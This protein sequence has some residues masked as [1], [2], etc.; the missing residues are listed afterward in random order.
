MTH[1]V[2]RGVYGALFDDPDFQTLTSDAR[3]VLL[4]VR[5]CAQAGPAAIFRYYLELLACQTGMPQERVAAALAELAESPSEDHPWIVYDKAIVWV[6]NGLRHDPTMRLAN[7]KHA[8]AVRRAVAGLPRHD[9]VAMFCDYYGLAKPF[10]SLSNDSP[11]L[12]LRIPK[13]TEVLPEPSRGTTRTF[14]K[15]TEEDFKTAR[16]ATRR[17]PRRRDGASDPGIRQVLD[18]YQAVFVANNGEKPNITGKDAALVKQLIRRHGVEKVL[19]VLKAMFESADPF[20][21]QSGRTMGVLSSQW[22]KLVSVQHG[23]IL[24]PKT[25]GN[26]AA[27]QRFLDRMEGRA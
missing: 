10:D 16:T 9:I 20:I 13:K 15:K 14:P 6:R 5:L 4:T 7:R 1:G 2:H 3:L 12:A 26:L 19:A 8:E 25:A 21:M 22:N 27:G 17:P 18:A 24:T 23:P 11:G